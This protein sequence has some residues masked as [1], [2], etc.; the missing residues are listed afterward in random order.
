MSLSSSTSPA[1]PIPK[2][3]PTLPFANLCP[4]GSPAWWIPWFWLFLLRNLLWNISKDGDLDMRVFS[5]I[6][7]IWS[8][9]RTPRGK[10]ATLESSNWLAECRPYWLALP[11]TDPETR[12]YSSGFPVTS[13]LLLL[14]AC[15]CHGRPWSWRNPPVAHQ[16]AA[17][18]SAQSYLMS[19]SA[20]P[21]PPLSLSPW[22]VFL[23]FLN[24]SMSQ[25]ED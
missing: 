10:R 6:Q 20:Y 25:E 7:G 11:V 8:Y 13:L 9:S 1:L 3:S 16:D 14:W 12:M 2:Y 23:A 22:A 15:S 24:G 17:A 18:L 19:M 5:W 4:Y 21:S